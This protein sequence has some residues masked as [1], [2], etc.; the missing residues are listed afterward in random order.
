[1]KTPIGVIRG[2]IS[3]LKD[4]DFGQLTLTDEQNEIFKKIDN[5][6]LNLIEKINTLLKDNY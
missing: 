3:M 6:L 4:G 1:L 5:D 2:Y